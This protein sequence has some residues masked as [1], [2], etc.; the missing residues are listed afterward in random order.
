VLIVAD[1]AN[2]DDADPKFLKLHPFV[3]RAKHPNQTPRG[4]SI[5]R[6]QSALVR[7]E[8]F[9]LATVLGWV[10]ASPSHSVT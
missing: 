4:F 10:E 8:Y 7:L 2:A 9:L 3:P 1:S 6:W 5:L